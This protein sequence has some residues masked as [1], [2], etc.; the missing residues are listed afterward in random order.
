M[1]GPRLST[2]TTLK[3]SANLVAASAIAG[4]LVFLTAEAP[5]AS[6]DVTGAQ[7]Q[8]AAKS[9]RVPA[10]VKGTACSARGWPHFEQNC[11]FDDRTS[12]DDVRTVRVITLR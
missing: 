12:A 3:A 5:K 4:L 1:R 8:R 9:E 10:S 6:A 2:T 7:V 11:L